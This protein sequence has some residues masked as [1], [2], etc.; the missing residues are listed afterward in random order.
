MEES[1]TKW[2]LLAG[3]INNILKYFKYDLPSGNSWQ[4]TYNATHAH[5]HTYIYIYIQT[6]YMHDVHSQ[7]INKQQYNYIYMCVCIL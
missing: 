2:R 5:T 7:H 1:S 6:V 4:L 3:K